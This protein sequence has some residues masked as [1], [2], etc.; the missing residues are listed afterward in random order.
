MRNTNLTKP[1]G[2]L[3]L[4]CFIP[5]WVFSQNITVKGLV[6]DANGE[7]LLGV[8]VRE[9]GS[10]V[11]TVT[12]LDGNFTIQVKNN[13]KLQF[14]FVGYISQTV[15]VDGRT[16]MT[17]TLKEDS[18]TLEEVVVIGYGSQRK[19]AVTGSVA[20]MKGDI[21]REVP[22]ANISR[23]LQG[24][25][26]GVEMSQTSS[27]PGAE[28]QIRIR[29]ARSLTG[30]NDPLVVL[31]GIPFAGSISDI[32]PDDIK[33]IDILKDASAT[34]IYG[35][36][37][38]NGVI[39]VTSNKGSKGQQAH[40][41]YNGYYG[42]KQAIKFPMMDGAEFALLRKTAVQKYTNG[43]DE[44][45]DV[46]TNWQ[47]LL[48]QTGIVTNHDI[49]VS[50][51]SEKGSYNF[52]VSYYNDQAVVPL[53]NYSRYAIRG[54]LD[55]EIGKLFRLGFTVNNNY[56]VNNGNNLGIYSSLSTS[57]I[58]NPYKEDGTLKRTVKMT[59]DENWV[60][61][62]QSLENLGD[63]YID[64]TRALSSY[65][66]MYVEVKCP[67]VEG[68]KYR[69]N[70]GLNYRQ[71][72]YGN[73]TGVGAF[74]TN[75]TAVSTATINNTH[76]VNWAIE[77]LLTYDRTFA[78]KHKVNAVAMYS[79]E[80]TTYWKSGATAKDIPSDAFQFYNLGLAAGDIS[81][82]SG[83]QSYWQAGLMSVMGRVMYSYND[84]YMIS[85]T[86]RSDGSSRLAPGHQWNTYP[87]VSV[88]WNIKDESFMKNIS[89]ID[90]LKLRVGYGETSNQ[91]INPYK[92]LG[93]LNTRYYNFGTTNT[94]GLY[95]S[96]LPSPKLGWEFSRTWNYG[97]DFSLLNH[98]LT[99]TFEYYVMNTDNVLQSVNLPATAGV[100]SYTANVGNTQ[101]KGWEFSLNGV[102]LDNVNGWTWEAGVNVYSNHNKLV[103]LASGQQEDK[104][105]LWFVGHSINSI[106]DY[107]RI[108]IWQ[109][110][111]PYLNILEG[112]AG[113]VGMIKV[114]YTG[115]Y[116]TDGT[117]T[118][119][120]NTDDKQVIDT[121]PN[122][123]GGFNTRVAYKGFDLAVVGAFQNG[124][125]LNSTLYG[126][127]G[128]L[129]MLNGRRGNV[130]VDYWTET[131]TS[132]KY[133]KPG[134]VGSD[135]PTYGSTLG[136]FSA[137]YLKVRT[138]TLGYNFNQK[139]LKNTG[140]EKLRL[141]CTVENPF[142]LFSPYRNE[143]GMDPEPNSYGD[144][145]VAVSG[146][147]RMLIV[148][149]NTP[150]THNYLV[151]LNVT[152]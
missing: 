111:D 60:T 23:A 19:E 46:N 57:P 112:K 139:W 2:L 95:V 41:T 7:P 59:M 71:T 79:A 39:L 24:R 47:G 49:G 48:Y 20:S 99:G 150:T 116:N 66:T 69:A 81:V 141:Y 103:S 56:S 92:T 89:Q 91:A 16:K 80:Q 3:F 134:V 149:T 96:E 26:A 135:A 36:R 101:N 70:V 32:S 15:P 18:K 75:S 33:T 118:R 123:Q 152:F 130:K 78:Q 62:K 83:D 17:V 147:H 87:A 126:T 115:T 97:L 29:G 90:A 88:G 30:A 85:A 133:P 86:V 34:A 42:L 93:L 143:S 114:E 104:D 65:N 125:I 144:Q 105:N 110:N 120:I 74:S 67:G 145:N 54:S 127:S 72:N 94:S 128:Y 129:N 31:D 9:V 113:K 37:G 119:Q 43:G 138:I 109:A 102:I 6:K 84:R 52:G 140:I 142:V 27:K 35:S 21:L 14:S 136:Y 146:T 5:F 63:Q 61:T 73:Y 148:G 151:G 121:D 13:A 55:Q 22:A 38:S 98:R 76:N 132:A 77:N 106:Y 8:N 40:L 4:F 58:A 53:Q 82:K 131:N 107:K 108:G 28:M 1:L 51:G 137:S 44:A 122:F 10:N 64:Q 12:D 100:G 11:G 45:D 25:V 124:G 117:P 68:L 50:G